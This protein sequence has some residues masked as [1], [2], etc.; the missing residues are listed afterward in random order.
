MGET[1]KLSGYR[2]QPVEGGPQ[3]DWHPNPVG[4]DVL[5]YFYIEDTDAWGEVDGTWTVYRYESDTAPPPPE[6]ETE[7]GILVV[8]VEEEERVEVCVWG[9]YT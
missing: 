3:V 6:D 7:F 4:W 1:L 8:Y 2:E 5:Y 9:S